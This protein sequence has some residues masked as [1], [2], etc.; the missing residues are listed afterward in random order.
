MTAAQ[1]HINVLYLVS[2]GKFN[3]KLG[4]ISK[5]GKFPDSDKT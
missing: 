3:Y 1:Y 4:R 2:E 5:R